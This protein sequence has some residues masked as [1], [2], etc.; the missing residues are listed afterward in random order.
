MEKEEFLIWCKNYLM[1]MAFQNRLT[2]MPFSQ[3]NRF[4]LSGSRCLLTTYV[5]GTTP[6]PYDNYFKSR[7][8]KIYNKS[9]TNVFLK[10][11]KPYITVNPQLKKSLLS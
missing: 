9:P 6:I 10:R 7:I 2:M 8:I 1:N 4:D 11:K 3:N 5:S